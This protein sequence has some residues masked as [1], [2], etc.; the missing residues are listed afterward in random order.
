[1]QATATGSPNAPGSQAMNLSITPVTAITPSGP[2]TPYL[3]VPQGPGSASGPS[4]ATTSS[5]TLHRLATV[6][7]SN[8][9]HDK[10]AERKKLCDAL[11]DA[12][13]EIPVS[14][15]LDNVGLLADLS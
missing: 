9:G 11:I 3:T 6:S 7:S 13:G 15:D 10:K 12:G 8:A 1:M 14:L 2:T 4:S 5:A